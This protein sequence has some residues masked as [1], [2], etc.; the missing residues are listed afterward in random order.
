MEEMNCDTHIC[1]WRRAFLFDNP[2][3]RLFHNP[4]K[5]FSPYLSAGMTA[6]DIGC[7]LGF[8]SIGMAKIV[9]ERG[10]VISV[11][12]QQKMLNTLKKRAKRKSVHHIIRFHQCSES[13]IGLDMKADFILTFWVVHEAPDQKALLQEIFSLLRPGRHYFLAE[14]K[15]HISESQINVT[16]KYAIEAGFK[17]IDEPNIAFSRAFVYEKPS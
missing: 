10:Q 14:P 4:R 11:D 13:A 17:K 6:I 5:M 16:S 2:L 8:F 12:V 7:G 15:R 3:R 9:G 1:P